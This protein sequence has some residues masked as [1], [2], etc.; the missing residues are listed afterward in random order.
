MFELCMLESTQLLIFQDV[1]SVQ[2]LGFPHTLF[3]TDIFVEHTLVFAIVNVVKCEGEIRV[4]A[5]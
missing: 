1:K 4:K 3:S 2:N 5:L